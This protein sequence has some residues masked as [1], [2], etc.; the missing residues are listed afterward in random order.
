MKR[1]GR[2]GA[3]RVTLT[4]PDRNGLLD[5]DQLP[6]GRLRPGYLWRHPALRAGVMAVIVLWL[7]TTAGNAVHQLNKFGRGGVGTAELVDF[8]T[9]R[10][11]FLAS[12]GRVIDFYDQTPFWWFDHEGD[13]KAVVYDPRS[14]EGTHVLR[15][16]LFEEAAGDLIAALIISILGW[17]YL[18]RRWRKL[19]STAE[20]WRF[21]V[22]ILTE[23]FVAS[24]DEI[25]SAVLPSGPARASVLP[26]SF[27]AN[28]MEPVVV[29]GKL[30]AILTGRDYDQVCENPRQGLMIANDRRN[31]VFAVTEELR[32]ALAV[33]GDGRLRM[34]A[35]E[36][37]P[38]KEI[39][40]VDAEG[41][42][43]V[44]NA[45]LELGD[46]AR[47]ARL[48]SEG[49]YCWTCLDVGGG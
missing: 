31:S 10:W 13:T 14:P 38:T 28:G 40:A 5:G 25:A 45:V 9:D 32:D 42:A 21:R 8:R 33:S 43:G 47:I 30:E 19:R 22:W 11:R 39:A 37:A 46:I 27:D 1:R 23:Y 35:E 16:D 12:D 20:D 3:R 49:M 15:R 44:V 7:C 34:A 24:S 36:L 17:R 6:Q 4:R 48:R 2:S 18:A 41:V 29:M 26:V